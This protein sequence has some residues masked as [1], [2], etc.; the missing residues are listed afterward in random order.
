MLG[1]VAIA[2]ATATAT[3]TANNNFVGDLPVVGF[4]EVDTTLG[5]LRGLTVEYE[6]KHL[7][8]FRGIRYTEPPVNERRFLRSELINKTWEGVQ[9]ATSYGAVCIQNPAADPNMQVHPEAPPPNEDCL[10][11]NVFTPV[12]PP[13]KVPE[14]AFAERGGEHNRGSPL[15]TP[16]T[17]AHH[18]VSTTSER[19]STLLPV[20]V[21]IH[22]GGLCIGSSSEAWGTGY[23][24]IKEENVVLVNFNY[25]LGALGFMV[26]NSS[27]RGGLPDDKFV[28]MHWTLPLSSSALGLF[29]WA[30]AD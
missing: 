4:P 1:A 23:D 11:I 3:V 5:R 18:E 30:S 14:K 27:T 26:S 17:H 15:N 19:A 21:W 28:G 12:S 10:Y 22:G 24:L 6:G 29:G 9:N 2:T 8:S 16:S 13:E 7:N 25:R 20:L